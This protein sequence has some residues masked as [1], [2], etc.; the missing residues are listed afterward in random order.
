MLVQ[1]RDKLV[2]DLVGRLRTKRYRAKRVRR[3]YIPK[4][5]GKERPIGIPALEDKLV[6]GACAKLLAAIY[7]QDFLDSSY[8]YRPGRGALDAVARADL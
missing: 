6:R 2:Q 1:L 8:G 7:E 5:N 4:E 3:V